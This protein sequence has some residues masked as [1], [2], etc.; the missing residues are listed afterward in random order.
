MRT[1]TVVQPLRLVYNLRISVVPELPSVF[2]KQASRWFLK[3]NQGAL[4]FQSSS[5]PEYPLQHISAAI[6]CRCMSS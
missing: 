3:H 2:A 1:S 4:H 6:Q 5:T